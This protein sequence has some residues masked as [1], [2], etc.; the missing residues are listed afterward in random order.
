[1]KILAFGEVML[2]MMPSDYKTLTQVDTLEFL[3]TGT[4]VNILSSLYQM[5]N[6]VYL[7]TCLPDNAVGKAASAHM[8]KLGIHDEFIQYRG[9][10]MGIYFLEK[11]IG[12][13]ASQVTY[14][15]RKDSSFGLS[16]V[17]D[18]DFNCLD[19]MDAL[20]LCGISLALNQE[21]RD[22][23]M[24][25]VKEAKKRHI[26]VIFD[27]NFRP[28]LWND[29]TRPY[30]KD[31]YEQ[32]LKEADIVFAGIKD[33]TLLLEKAIDP[34][35][36]HSLQLES[37]LKQM[38]DDYHIEVI[39]GTERRQEDGQDY[40]SGYMMKNGQLIRSQKHALIVYDRVGGGDGFAAGAIHAYLHQMEQPLLIEYAT[41]S[42]VF[43]HTT[44][45]DSPI[46]GYDEIM[47]YIKHGKSDIRR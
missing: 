44:Y 17:T 21:L 4:G 10:H 45:G 47:D 25:F 28:S 42:G 24:T 38:C 13:R 14:L 35:L 11:G 7:T 34:T 31:I 15:N 9:N 19:G 37:A 29:E 23:A 16:Q 30:A 18:Y 33:A 5:G 6:D 12:Q 26:K 20:H 46:T 2:R 1:M 32:M 41:V 43:A 39:F 36:P 8:R 40:L 22:V 27:C 3:F